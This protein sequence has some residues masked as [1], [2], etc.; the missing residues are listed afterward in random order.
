MGRGVKLKGM[1]VILLK[2]KDR[3]TG[4][5]IS[6]HMIVWGRMLIV[7]RGCSRISC[8]PSPSTFAVDT[9]K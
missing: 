1:I 3:N 2:D 4:Y 5:M 6:V 8:G 7:N 9:T